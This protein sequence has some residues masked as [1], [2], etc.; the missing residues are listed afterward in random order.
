MRGMLKVLLYIA[1]GFLKKKIFVQSFEMQAKLYT[2]I[3]YHLYLKKQ[4]TYKL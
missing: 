1:F 4:L 2:F 3:D